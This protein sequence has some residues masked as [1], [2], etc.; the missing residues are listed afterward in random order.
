[1][2]WVGEFA[3][4]GLAPTVAVSAATW[5][6]SRL[7][8]RLPE[9]RRWQ[10]AEPD[11]LTICVAKKLPADAAASP[12]YTGI[13]QTMALAVIAPSLA[14]GYPR[15]PFPRLHFPDQVSDEIENDLVLLGGPKT[16][17][18]SAEALRLIADRT[19]VD[20]GPEAL[21]IRGRDPIPHLRTGDLDHDVGVVARIANPWS[22]RRR[23]LVVLA[24][25]H[26]YGV[27]AAARFF[28]EKVRPFAATYRGPFVAVVRSPIK[29]A[30]VLP[31]AEVFVAPAG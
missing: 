2:T 23:T 9:R 14:R 30:Y 13:G 26:T 8:D 22:R 25:A 24:G 20:L 3:T 31:A 18:L 4:T 1:M 29:N 15:T 5:T 10:L 27:A 19:G 11:R 16:N 17:D 7:K 6:A 28:V 21:L 12:P